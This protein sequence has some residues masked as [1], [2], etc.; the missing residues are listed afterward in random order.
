M[1]AIMGLNLSTGRS[2]PGAS[3]DQNYAL[4][5][6]L[7]DQFE[8]KFGS[9]QC[10]TLTGVNLGTSEGQAAFREK[11]QIENCLDYVAEAIRL[12]ISLVDETYI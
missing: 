9:T 1:G 6:E 4:V 2:E 12:V 5:I 7:I 8:D 10:K 11:G 3:V